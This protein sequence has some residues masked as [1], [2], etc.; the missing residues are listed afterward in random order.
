M[1]RGWIRGLSPRL[2]YLTQPFKWHFQ[3]ACSPQE[4]RHNTHEVTRVQKLEVGVQQGQWLTW[5]RSAWTEVSWFVFICILS[6]A[7]FRTTTPLKGCKRRGKGKV[8]WD[9]QGYLACDSRWNALKYLDEEKEKQ[10]METKGSKRSG[11]THSCPTVLEE[12][13]K[14]K[15]WNVLNLLLQKGV[16]NILNGLT[17]SQATLSRHRW[18]FLKLSHTLTKMGNSQNIAN[19]TKNA[20]FPTRRED[21]GFFVGLFVCFK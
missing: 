18:G 8:G 10:S 20:I 9:I 16:F 12:R 7:C 14:K 17:H 5:H 19:Y 3:Q 15:D 2:N 6:I 4:K 1:Q 11:R 13:K 21:V